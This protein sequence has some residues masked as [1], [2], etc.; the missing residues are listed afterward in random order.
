M[1]L[2]SARFALRHWEDSGRGRGVPERGVQLPGGRAEFRASKWR[3]PENNRRRGAGSAAESRE[4]C[5]AAQR[6]TVTGIK[7][8]GEAETLEPTRSLNASRGRPAAS[9]SAVGSMASMPTSP[10]A[11]R[12]VP[13]GGGNDHPK[14]FK[15]RW[16]PVLKSIALSGDL[17]TGERV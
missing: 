5:F 3:G 7:A 11:V 15:T 12:R 8:D 17:M 16:F 9:A 2:S 13:P 14:L 6:Q 4:H 1:R 10:M